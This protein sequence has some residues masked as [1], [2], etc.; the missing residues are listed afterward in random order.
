MSM[1]VGGSFSMLTGGGS[2]DLIALHDVLAGGLGTTGITDQG[3]VSGWTIV[4]VYKDAPSA[5][6]GREA[7]QWVN[8]DDNAGEYEVGLVCV[9][10]V[11]IVYYYLR[12]TVVSGDDPYGEPGNPTK[13]AWISLANTFDL[14]TS[15]NGSQALSGQIK[16]EISANQTDVI[17]S[18]LI[19]WVA[20]GYK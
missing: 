11:N 20:D 2:D 12:W 4:W 1:I 7:A 14:R 10:S 19:D 8:D 5:P 6:V 16:L 3:G 9:P 15:T 17:T 18:C 13:N